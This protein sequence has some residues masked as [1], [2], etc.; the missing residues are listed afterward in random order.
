MRD[1]SQ[2][3]EERAE[4]QAEAAA[5]H[6]APAQHLSEFTPVHVPSPKLDRVP[7]L[8]V[9]VFV[10][11]SFGL[12]WLAASPLWIMGPT[13][14]SFP[15]ALPVFGSVM[16]FTPTIAMLVVVFLFRTPPKGDRLRFLGIWPLRPAKRTVW[17][18]VIGLFAPIAIAVLAI[19]IAV[20]FGWV[21]LDLVEFSGLRAMLAA[22]LPESAMASMPPFGLLIAVQL[23]ML[24]LGAV[25]N[26]GTAFGEEFGWRGWLV[27]VL[28]PLGTWPALVI[29]GAIWGLWHSPLILLGYNFGLTDWRG[30]ALMTIACVFWGVLLG[31]LRLRS[32]SVWPA[33]IAHGSLNA[34]ASLVLLFA[35]AE[36]APQA[37]LATP[38]GAAGWIAIAIVVA[39][40]V[41][42]GQF[43][44]KRQPDLATPRSMQ[45]ARQAAAG[46]KAATQVGDGA[47]TPG[48]DEGAGRP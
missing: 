6:P 36:P 38:L 14:P 21:K 10:A 11:V 12:A 34:C 27:P 39:V 33:V 18:I 48:V 15:I 40:L 19:A 22:T 8:A 41:A 3:E 1:T 25:V 24:P 28:R 17:L 42:F 13:S 29:S 4:P 23:L 45:L 44:P 26:S 37:A 5:Q 16:M 30:V 7:W 47:P 35:A 32:G 2:N 31:W 46:V 43:S 9:I 20:L